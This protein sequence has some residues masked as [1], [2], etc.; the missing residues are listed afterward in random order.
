[1]FWFL[2]SSCSNATTS[3]GIDRSAGQA[4][5]QAW[6]LRSN[7]GLARPKKVCAA[8]PRQIRR[9]AAFEGWLSFVDCNYFCPGFRPARCLLRPKFIRQQAPQGFI[10]IRDGH[11][12]FWY[13][14]TVAVTGACPE[15]QLPLWCCLVCHG[16]SVLLKRRQVS[17]CKRYLQCL[18]DADWFANTHGASDTTASLLPGTTSSTLVFHR[19]QDIGSFI[20][21]GN[22]HGAD[23]LQCSVVQFLWGTR[24]QARHADEL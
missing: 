14:K 11:E 21:L 19:G 16:K 4:V 10:T 24:M 3:R 9:V 5:A 20:L 1:M 6:A 7:V 12:R 13:Y 8:L 18:K 15:W 2:N 22:T 17:A 23:K